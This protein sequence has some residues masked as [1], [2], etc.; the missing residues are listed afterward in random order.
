MPYR[1]R[2]RAVHHPAPHAARSPQTDGGDDDEK[3]ELDDTDS[4]ERND[5]TKNDNVSGFRTRIA[6]YEKKT[7][8]I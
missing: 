5:E 6:L 3:D 2:K 1:R 4:S 7:G 8:S